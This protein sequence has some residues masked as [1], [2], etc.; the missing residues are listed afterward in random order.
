MPSPVSVLVVD[1]SAV[2][3]P[4]VDTPPGAGARPRAGTPPPPRSAVGGPPPAKAA[5]APTPPLPSQRLVAIGA[6]TGGTEALRDV[7]KAMP[8]DAPGIV[9]VQHMPQGF[10]AAFADHLDAVCKIA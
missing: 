5:R 9:I 4:P 7:L 8:A 1:D 10:T 3:R 2:G 6:S